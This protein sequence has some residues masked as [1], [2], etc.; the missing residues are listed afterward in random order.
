MLNVSLIIRT[1]NEEKNI[2][3]CILSCINNNINEII[4]V[5]GYSTD[6]TK[7]IVENLIVLYSNIK[8]IQTTKGLVNQKMLVLKNLL[9]TM[10][11]LQ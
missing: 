11:I 1:F 9:H 3:E 5:D 7:K 10:I 2:E 6:C 4:I 8:F